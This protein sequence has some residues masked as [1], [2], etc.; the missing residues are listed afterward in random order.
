MR[1]DNQRI[2]EPLHLTL[3]DSAAGCLRVAC[4]SQGLP[5]GIIGMPGDLS[6]DPLDD[7]VERLNYMKACYNEYDDWLIDRSDAF[8]SWRLLIDTLWLRQWQ[9]L[10]GQHDPTG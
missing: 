5:G 2:T 4:Q 9:A 6:H 10:P 3:G 7:G 8:E 1:G